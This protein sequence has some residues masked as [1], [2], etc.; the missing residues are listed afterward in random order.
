MTQQNQTTI[1]HLVWLPYGFDLFKQFI[2]SYCTFDAGIAHDL[3]IVFNGVH[4]SNSTQPYH[5][6]LG[7]LGVQYK[8]INIKTGQDLEC[9]FT[10]SKTLKTEYIFVLNSFAVVLANNWLLQ[11]MVL[12]SAANVGMVGATGSWQSY[13]SSVYQK[14]TGKWETHKGFAYNFRKYKLFIKTF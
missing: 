13:Y 2:A 6:W 3:L 4:D 7:Q 9:Y 8:S 14:H 1:I 11:Y 5:D 10:A 12:F